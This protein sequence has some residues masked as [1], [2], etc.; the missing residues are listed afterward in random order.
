M[1]KQSIFGSTFSI[2]VEIPPKYV[3]RRFQPLL[4]AL[5]IVEHVDVDTKRSHWVPNRGYTLVDPSIRYFGRSK[6]SVVSAEIC[7]FAVS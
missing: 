7:D 6:K 2:Q 4:L 5:E 3:F 1:K